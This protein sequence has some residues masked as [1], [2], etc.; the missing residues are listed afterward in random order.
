M[1]EV[2]VNAGT[3]QQPAHEIEGRLPVLDAT[4]RLVAVKVVV[5]DAFRI[6]DRDPLLV[7][8]DAKQDLLHGFVAEGPAVGFKF[9]QRELR[10]DLGPILVEAAHRAGPDLLEFAHDPVEIAGAAGILGLH[11]DRGLL[12]QDVSR[13]NGGRGFLT[14]HFDSDLVRAA[15]LLPDL[16]LVE[17]QVVGVASCDV[18]AD[19]PVLLGRPLFS[20]EI[21]RQSRG[22]DRC[23]HAR[24]H[25]RG[26][27]ASQLTLP[28]PRVPDSGPAPGDH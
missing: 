17:K 10:D 11:P 6:F 24:E 2:V 8:D 7:L 1:S 23:T 25:C 26:T 14:L 20:R 13:G 3:F 27:G 18:D 5:L 9:Q 4:A 15:Q 16:H 22:V 12:S 19:R 28:L 21:H